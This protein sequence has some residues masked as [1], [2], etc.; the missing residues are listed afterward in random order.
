MSSIHGNESEYI[1]SLFNEGAEFKA[2]T[3]EKM[4]FYTN[5]ET[6]YWK[7]KEMELIG[8]NRKPVFLIF[9]NTPLFMNRS[10]VDLDGNEPLRSIS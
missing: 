9:E 1:K 6:I 10:S 4:H 7:C 8:I 3:S 5:V 2:R